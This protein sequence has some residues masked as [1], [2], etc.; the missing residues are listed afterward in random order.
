MR[1]LTFLFSLPVLLAGILSASAVAA[2]KR[3]ALVVGNSAYRNVTRLDNPANDAKLLSETLRS[4]GFTLVGGGAQLDLDKASFDRTVQAFGAQLAGADVGLFYYAGHGVQVRGE[5]YLIPVD[6]NPT[7]EADV[8]FQ[9]LDTNLV[10]RQME[11]AGT[12][13][14]IVILDACR[15]NPFGGRGLAVG[16]AQDGDNTRMRAATGGLAQMQAPEGTLISFA[17]QPGNVAQDGADGNSPYARA[18]ADTIRKPGIGIFD[19]FNQVGLL[20]K[21][22]TGGAQQPWVSSSPIDGTFYF[23]PSAGAA[24]PSVASGPAADEITWNYLKGMTDVG[25][26]RRF[27]D[28]F[29]SGTHKS[30]AEARIAALEQEKRVA[31]VTPPVA[32]TAPPTLVAAVG[33]LPPERERAL[34][35]KDSFKECEGCPAMITMPAGSFTMGSPASELQRGSDEGP[36]QEVVIRRAFAVGRSQ[37]SFE[38]WLACVAE[39]GCNAYRPG[40]YGWGFGKRP[41][42]NVSWT[43]AKA[44]VK[45]L[46]EKTGAPYRLLSESEREYV[47]RGCTSPACPSTPFWFGKEISPA[48]ANYDWHYSY[49]GSAKAQPPRRTVATDASEA[50]PF[51]LLHVHGNVWEWVEDCWNASLAG[52]PNDGAPRITG[53][54]N[55]RVIRGGAWSDEPKDLRSAKRSWEVIGERRAEIGFRVARTLRN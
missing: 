16:R 28:E 20:V 2:D 23:A 32:T 30:E 3:V 44:Y 22:A 12:R 45:W 52:L 19:A 34:K 21:R 13:L 31:A 51:G 54:C 48:R 6:A 36:Q 35:P 18:L 49:D 47:T 9:M 1:R 38:E 25:A 37:V 17:T 33:P 55:S 27:A 7:K 15:N 50:N 29:P 40:D 26:L 41:V 53:D 11:G 42:I 5:N 10:L 43:D 39:G 46:S 4:L 14:N 24:A 8:D